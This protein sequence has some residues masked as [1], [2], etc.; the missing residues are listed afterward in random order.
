MNRCLQGAHVLEWM[1]KG[2]TTRDPSKGT[3]LN[4][5]W[6]ITCLP[7]M[8]K[9]LT[10]Q[11]R[12][13]IYNSLASRGLFPEEQK[14]CCKVS[15][16]TVELLYIDPKREQDQMEKSSYGLHWLQ[17]GRWYG[18]AKVNNKLSLNVQNISWSHKL[19]RENHENLESGIDSRR[20]KLSWSK[21]PKRYFSRRCTITVT[22]HNCHYTT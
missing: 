1:T 15:R 21:D 17:K 5:Y 7:M 14:G 2:K 10:A 4:N 18:P 6:P 19:Y 12:E 11:I 9:I 16:G 8:W 20:K 3:A 13:E 22:I